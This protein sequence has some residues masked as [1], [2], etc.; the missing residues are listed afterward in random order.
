LCQASIYW[1]REHDYQ[2]VLAPGT[3]AGLFEFAAWAGGLPWRTYQKLGFVDA[4]LEVGDDLPEWAKGNSPP[5]VMESV[6][7]ALAA[8]L[9][10]REFHSRLMVLRLK[11]QL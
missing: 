6:R 1:A 5:E 7:T 11:G 4:A 9:P 8:G 3:P 10:Q 2:A